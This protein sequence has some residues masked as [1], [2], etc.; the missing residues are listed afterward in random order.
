[1]NERLFQLVQEGLPVLRH[2]ARGLARRLGGDVEV[3][4]LI[5]LGHP[6]LMEVART[7]EPHRSKFSTFAALKMKWAILDGLRREA[8]ARPSWTRARVAA[9]A[10]SERLAE[11][12]CAAE[13]E[14]G[15]PVTEDACKARLRALLEGQAAAIALGLTVEREDTVER[16]PDSVDSPEETAS[17][18]ELRRDIRRAVG[19]LPDRERALVE[20]HYFGGEPFDEIAKDLGVSKSWASRLHASAIGKLAEALRD[21]D[22]NRAEE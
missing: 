17:R 8:R 13:M 12:A 1:M 10:R 19:T 7:F 4:E 18:S 3:D 5:A 20:R 15:I 21:V 2:V 9:V 14:R 22:P 6:A 16:I 11:D